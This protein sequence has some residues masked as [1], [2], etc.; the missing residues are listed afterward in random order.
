MIHHSR[1]GK[2]NPCPSGSNPDGASYPPNILNRKGI[3]ITTSKTRDACVSAIILSSPPISPPIM[4]ISFK[5]PGA[6]EK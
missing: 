5:P 6:A 1:I 2:S 4:V 3:V